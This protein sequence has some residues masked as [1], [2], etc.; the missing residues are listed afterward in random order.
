MSHS[1]QGEN[2]C[3]II[4]ELLYVYNMNV[5]FGSVLHQEFTIPTICSSHWTGMR[6]N[7]RRAHPALRTL[8]LLWITLSTLKGTLWKFCLNMVIDFC[9]NY[10]CV[11]TPLSLVYLFVRVYDFE[12]ITTTAQYN[13]TICCLCIWCCA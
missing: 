3:C 2:M 1:L 9:L 11:S 10:T 12:Y 8:P 7:G 6:R 13:F 5:Y 4:C